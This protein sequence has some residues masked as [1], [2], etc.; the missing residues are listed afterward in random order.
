LIDEI[1]IHQ[2][3]PVKLAFDITASLVSN[4][5]LWNHKL[6]AGI[7]SRY[8][9]PVIGSV[10][11]LRFADLER[12][13]E[14]RRAKYVL[15]H[16]PPASTALRLGGDTLMAVG[17]WRRKPSWM[18]AGGLLVVA[19]WSHGLVL[20]PTVWGGPAAKRLGWG[21]PNSTDR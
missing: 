19:G 7:A 12:L 1:L 10:L 4:A 11:V 14:T 21:E 9:L 18:V 6:A 2:V 15:E 5:M 13:R 17:A 20:L 16:V 8:L 3:H